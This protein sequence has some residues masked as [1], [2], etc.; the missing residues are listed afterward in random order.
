MDENELEK[1]K[2]YQQYQQYLKDKE[3]NTP[4]DMKAGAAK[5]ATNAIQ[6]MT[7]G[8]DK[9][10]ALGGGL[11]TMG[12]A[13]ANPWLMGAGLALS[14]AGSIKQGQNQRAQQRYQAEIKKLQDRQDAINRLAQ[15]GQGLKA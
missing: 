5:G 3:E 11:T 12:A 6:G 13:T 2:E 1:Y 8:Q 15:I 10:T 4:V 9:A 14:T 7:Q